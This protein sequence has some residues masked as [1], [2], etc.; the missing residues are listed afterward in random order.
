VAHYVNGVNDG[1]QDTETEQ[2]DEAAENG[3]DD[4]AMDSDSTLSLGNC[5]DDDDDFFM[6]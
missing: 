5:Y 1:G 2:G 6:L 3:D 4:D